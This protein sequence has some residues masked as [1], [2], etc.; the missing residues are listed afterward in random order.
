MIKIIESVNITP[1]LSA[2]H[3]ME[4]NFC[5]TNYGQK[6][7]V[8]MQYKLGDDPWTSAVGRS[9]G[10]EL[11]YNILNPFFKDTIFEEIIFKY[12]LIRSRLMWINPYSCYSMH[13]DETPRVHIPLV[14]N[15]QCFFVFKTGLID[16][17]TTDNIYWVD[18]TQS[19]TFMNCSEHP[20]LHLVGVVSNAR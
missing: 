11:S 20:R 15:P 5:W 4:K 8:G 6:K 16:H 1:I 13:K 2:Y 19:H 18:T 17:L 10:N 3:E 9:Q 12:N 14:T 7:Q